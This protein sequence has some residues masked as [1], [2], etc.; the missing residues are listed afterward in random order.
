MEIIV[1][2]KKYDM[3]KQLDS[4][5]YLDYLELREAIMKKEEEKIPYTKADFMKMAESVA[6]MY[7]NK[8]T[9]NELLASVP[10]ATVM[11]RFA[12]FDMDIV[13]GVD[14]RVKKMQTNFTQRK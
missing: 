2:K 7:G 11:L 3:S 1:N 9:A 8:F 10:P 14:Q 6:A 5:A 4:L 12:S 13:D